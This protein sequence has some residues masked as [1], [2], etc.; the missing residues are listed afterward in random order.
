MTDLGTLGGTY[1]QGLGI[2]ASG[3]VTGFASTTGGAQHAFV[4]DGATMY[5]LNA[6]VASGLGGAV[7]E[8][9]EGISDAGQIVAYGCGTICQAYLLDPVATSVAEP[10]GLA[11]VGIGLIG[12]AGIGRR[13]RW[14]RRT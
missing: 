2:N 11:L 10:G 5:D 4:Y 3:E 1:S 12:A 14:S 8:E 9:A 7:L 6:L 13:R